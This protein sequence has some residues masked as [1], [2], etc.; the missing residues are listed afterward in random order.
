MRCEKRIELLYKKE[1]KK[2][3]NLLEKLKKRQRKSDYY[4]FCDCEI[5][6]L[7]TK[8]ECLDYYNS[9][10]KPFA[11]TMIRVEK[12]WRLSRK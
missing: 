1:K 8:Q 12:T 6:F 9:L 2:T 11:M 3:D 7:G 10:P 5:M 4:V